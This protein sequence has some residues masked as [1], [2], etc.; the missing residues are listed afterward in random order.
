MDPETTINWRD[1]HELFFEKCKT[2]QH[3]Q[4]FVGEYLRSCDLDVQ[5]GELSFRDNPNVAEFGEGAAAEFAAARKFDIG[6]KEY[7]NTKDIVLYP[8]RPGKEPW[9]VEVKSRNGATKPKYRFDPRDMG[10]DKTTYPFGF[11][12]P[13]MICETV[14]G[15]KAKDPKPKVYIMVSDHNGAMIATW[16]DRT[17]NWSVKYNLDRERGVGEDKYYCDMGLFKPVDWFV[18]LFKK[19]NH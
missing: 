4:E 15:Y 3:W 11:G 1:N 2:G 8:R 12:F 9:V 13:D 14:S 10:R 6:R 17:Q 18:E 19:S 16:G 7:I 5:V